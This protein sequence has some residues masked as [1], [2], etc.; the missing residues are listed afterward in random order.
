M[1]S[2]QEKQNKPRTEKPKIEKPKGEKPKNE[3]PKE[4]QPAA[5]K[6]KDAEKDK[7]AHLLGITV[8]KTENFSV[9]YSQ[10]LT[11]SQ[12]IDFYDIS[13]CYIL[14]PWAYGIWEEIQRFF[15]SRIKPMGVENAYFPL[16]V[17]QK[18]LA[19]EKDHIEGFSAEVA[20]VTRAGSELAQ[21][22]AI[23]PTSETIM[24]PAFA[25]WIRSHRDLPMKLNQWTNVVRWEFKR[26]VP[27]IRSR[28]FLWQ[29]G[30][31]V[32]AT[33]EEASKEVLE[34][35][36]IYSKVY[37]ELLAVPVY[38]GYKSVGEK[39][40]GGYYT[41][42]IEAFIPANGRAVQAATSHCLGQNF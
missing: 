40:A 22:V 41:T 24:Y 10:V 13:G 15:D 28:E 16:L 25:E 7:D 42:S 33:L 8:K 35:L 26:P 2:S 30:H 3:K 29:E 17:S 23:R 31:T 27:F 37:E 4:K 36:E 32:F 12:M 20:W 19:T 18:S 6:G 1:D 11:K 21:P 34:I 39:F 5:G 14:R 38:K 9:W